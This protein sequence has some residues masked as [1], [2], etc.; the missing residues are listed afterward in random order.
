MIALYPRVSTQEQALNGNSI[1]EQIDRMKNYCAAMGWENYKIYNDAGYSGATMHRP[2]LQQLIEDV[3]KGKIEKVLVYKLDRLSRSQLDTLYLIEKVFVANNCG[4]VSMNENFDTTTPFGRAMIGILAVFAQLEREQIKERM[5][6]GKLARAKK[7]KTNSCAKPPIGYDYINDNLVINDYESMLVKRIYNEFLEGKTIYQI[8]KQLNDSGLHHKYGKWVHPTI[9]KILTSKTYTGYVKHNDY[10]YDGNF[11]AIIEEKMFNEVQEILKNNSDRH[12][13]KNLRPGKATSYLGG[14]SY[15][16]Q[17]GAKYFKRIVY[18]NHQRYYYYSCNSRIKSNKEYVTNPDC[19]NKNWKMEELDNLIINEIKKLAIDFNHHTVEKTNK[20]INSQFDI[21]NKK[22]DDINIQIN[23]LVDLYSLN[24]IPIE[25][26]NNKTI[27]LNEKKANL[28]KELNFLRKEQKS[29][30]SYEKAL[31]E[32][33]SFKDVLERNDFEEIR[34]V[35]E[36]LI[37]KI[38][39]DGDNITIYWAFD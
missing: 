38:T 34:L 5:T 22:V 7:G 8:S 36:T 4:F 28:E 37:D 6:M 12:I 21:I 32:I 10:Y 24:I 33:N 9:R 30:L 31:K 14:L 23:K 25:M 18:K 20:N 13:Y 19:K 1:D 16:Q 11:P 29:K 3:K 2:A 15:C 35:I 26:L 39:I 27:E 17:C